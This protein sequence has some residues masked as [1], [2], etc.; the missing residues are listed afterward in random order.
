MKNR[1]IRPD[2]STCIG[3]KNQMVKFL[4][5]AIKG[6]HCNT[7]TFDEI[8]CK[9]TDAGYFNMPRNTKGF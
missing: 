6:E 8:S 4:N 5:E 7:E 1:F 3:E 9:L 2:P